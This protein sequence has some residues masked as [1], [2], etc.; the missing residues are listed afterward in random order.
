MTK[1]KPRTDHSESPTKV[2]L[3]ADDLAQATGA[4]NKHLQL[5]RLL[6]VVN[7]LWLPGPQDEDAQSNAVAAVL[8]SLK[9]IGPVGELEVD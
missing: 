1:R 2:A 9:A 8:E 6:G 5:R 3:S 4:Q 7:T